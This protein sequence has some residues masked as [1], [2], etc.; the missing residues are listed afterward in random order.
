[1]KVLVIG[2]TGKQGS[3]V[4]R[5][6]LK[7]GHHVHA[8]TRNPTSPI[9]QELASLGASIVVG[10]I[11]NQASIEQALEEV[12]ALFAI[13]TRVPDGVEAEI[14]QGKTIANA[15][16]AKNKYLV[17]SSVASGDKKTGIPHFDSKTTI[18]NYF[19]EIGISPC[20]LAP[21]YFMENVFAMPQ[22]KEGQYLS[23][24]APNRRL[25]QVALAD[26]AAFATHALENPSRFKGKR[27]ELASDSLTGEQVVEILSK[28]SGKPI[29]YVQV[30]LEQIRDPDMAK[31]F[32]FFN[33]Q[34]FSVD[35][36]ELHRNYP[37]IPWHSYYSWAK[38]Q[39]W[40]NMPSLSH[41]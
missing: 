23:T 36:L 14:E 18:E 28:A 7:R 12:D 15:V 20:I 30:P 5:T 21:V 11:K 2:A 34:G 25:Q 41:P 32:S 39:N 38:E 26:I 35:I 3:H 4:A 10:N 40:Q 9:A 29:H 8:F 22:L 19:K 31:M 24:L 16:K 37:E 1:M 13:T 6:L 17:F 33:Q 27:I